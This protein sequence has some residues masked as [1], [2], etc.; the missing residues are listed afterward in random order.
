MPDVKQLTMGELRSGAETL[1]ASR[2]RCGVL[3][4]IV[5]RPQTDEQEILE[6]GQLD[7]LEGLV[8]D[9]WR[10]GQRARTPDGSFL[11]LTRNSP[12]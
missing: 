12:S 4:L 2:P 7:L 8:G 5:Q 11:T 6:K 10:T 1:S 9:G 3:Q